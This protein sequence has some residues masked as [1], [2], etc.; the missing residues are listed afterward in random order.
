MKIK[1]DDR[2]A[3]SI[4]LQK[5]PDNP[6]SFEEQ[7][8]AAKASGRRW[9]KSINVQTG[10]RAVYFYTPEEEAEIGRFAARTAERKKPWRKEL[11]ELRAEIASLRKP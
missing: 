3:E 10:E 1:T 7:M 8:A 2:I 6:V 5:R 9:G 11:D 4:A